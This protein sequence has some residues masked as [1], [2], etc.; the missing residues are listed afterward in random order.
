[1]HY[2]EANEEDLKMVIKVC[3]NMK[4]ELTVSGEKGCSK[5]K[6][7]KLFTN[8]NISKKVEIHPPKIISYKRKQEANQR[9]KGGGHG[10]AAKTF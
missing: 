6:D 3:N 9:R 2:A 7:L 4:K 1:M 5:S 8:C 10:G